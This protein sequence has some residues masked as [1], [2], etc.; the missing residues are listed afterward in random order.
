MKI[1]FKQFLESGFVLQKMRTD[2]NN[3]YALLN[4]VSICMEVED[5]LWLVIIEKKSKFVV[6]RLISFIVT[7]YSSNL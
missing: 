5:N 3:H 6:A 7:D 4:L 2:S 1:N